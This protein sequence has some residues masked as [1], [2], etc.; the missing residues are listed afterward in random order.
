MS[1]REKMKELMDKWDSVSVR[2]IADMCAATEESSEIFNEMWDFAKKNGF[3]NKNGV[4]FLNNESIEIYKNYGCL[5]HEKMIVSHP[6]GIFTV[7]L[8]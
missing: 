4:I 7:I 6:S 1:K 5:A 8:S 3:V 2:S